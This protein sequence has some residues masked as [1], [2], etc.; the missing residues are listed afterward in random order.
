MEQLI[1]EKK[2]VIMVCTGRHNTKNGGIVAHY[3]IFVLNRDAD[4]LYNISYI[5]K[6][7][8][9]KVNNKNEILINYCGSHKDMVAE[10]VSKHL[11]KEIQIITEI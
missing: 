4:R 6:K 2:S 3:L 8:G 7:I 11:G 5:M 9:F 10:E 1:R